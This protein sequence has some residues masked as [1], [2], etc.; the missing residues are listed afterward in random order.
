MCPCVCA[1]HS[2][3]LTG[4]VVHA[5][6]QYMVMTFSFHNFFNCQEYVLLHIEK[7]NSLF[8]YSPLLKG[9]VKSC[10]RDSHVSIMYFS[11]EPN[12]SNSHILFMHYCHE[13]NCPTNIMLRHFLL[14]YCTHEIG[15]FVNVHPIST[16][17]YHCGMH[18]EPWK[19]QIKPFHKEHLW[20]VA[21]KGKFCEKDICRVKLNPCG[22]I[23]TSR[24]LSGCLIL[25]IF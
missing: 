3:C 6:N 14:E 19:L 1:L 11:R 18:C 24:F 7:L 9:E 8:C 21:K 20:L 16:Q 17:T 5:S 15:L 12:I 22:Y 10:Y 25:S 2:W 13:P 4:V 23:R